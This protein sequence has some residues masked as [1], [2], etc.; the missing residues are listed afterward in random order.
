[1]HVCAHPVTLF[2]DARFNEN[3]SKRQERF[4]IIII[5]Y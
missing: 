2:L 3:S 4:I 1:M 5:I